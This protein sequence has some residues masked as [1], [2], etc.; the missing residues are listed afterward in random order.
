MLI[1][2]VDSFVSSVDFISSLLL[3]NQSLKNHPANVS[4]LEEEEFEFKNEFQDSF[5]NKSVVMISTISSHQQP[6]MVEILD[7]ELTRIPLHHNPAPFK[8]ISTIIPSDN[9]FDS[10]NTNVFIPNKSTAFVPATSGP[11]IHIPNYIKYLVSKSGDGKFFKRLGSDKIR[12]YNASLV[13]DCSSLTFGEV[14]R[15]HSLWTIFSILRNISNMQLPC[16]DIWVACEHVL[17]VVTGISSADLW[18]S[19]IIAAVYQSLQKPVSSA[20]LWDS[21]IIAA[22][23]QSLQKPVLNSALAECV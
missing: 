17:R 19:S 3:K 7:E 6:K 9:L 4:N 18:D 1:E 16:V 15:S 23:Y 2:A 12:S 22:V 21:S 20:D 5:S 14:N 13:I 10:L 8:V 11:L